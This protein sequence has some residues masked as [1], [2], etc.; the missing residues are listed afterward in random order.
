MALTQI[1]T[2]LKVNRETAIKMIAQ[3][4][5]AK[6]K[7]SEVHLRSYDRLIKA[8]YKGQRVELS[9]IENNLEIVSVLKME[10][11]EVM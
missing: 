4:F 9:D 7:T 6:K 8:T 2:G 11:R 1:E 5:Q 3:V 10:N